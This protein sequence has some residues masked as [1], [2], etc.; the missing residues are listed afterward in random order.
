[1]DCECHA[2]LEAYEAD[3]EMLAWREAQMALP[4]SQRRTRK[5]NHMVTKQ[6]MQLS[7]TMDAVQERVQHLVH[8][9]TTLPAGVERTF[10]C[11]RL[12]QTALGTAGEMMIESPKYGFP[13]AMVLTSLFAHVPELP[14][15]MRGIVKSTEYGCPLCVP[16]FSAAGKANGSDAFRRANGFKCAAALLLSRPQHYYCRFTVAIHANIC[17]RSLTCVKVLNSYSDARHCC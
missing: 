1:M 16:Q 15:L 8:H 4:K 5:I 3:A 2:G 11:I 17:C 6:F 9:Y 7:G 12:V 13:I 10:F 14:K